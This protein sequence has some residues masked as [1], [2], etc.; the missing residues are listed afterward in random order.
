M[1]EVTFSLRMQVV[2]HHSPSRVVASSRLRARSRSFL[3][4]V[5]SHPPPR[6]FSAALRA[7]A[8]TLGEGRAGVARVGRRFFSPFLLCFSSALAR[9]RPHALATLRGGARVV[10]QC[11]AR[12]GDA[13]RAFFLTFFLP[14]L[15]PSLSKTAS[16][17]PCFCT[18][19][20]C[21]PRSLAR[22][23]SRRFF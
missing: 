6:T 5:H 23:R 21:A 1:G 2:R 15:L 8:P 18:G 9:P 3:F 16:S 22:P 11:G 12:C 17:C 13:Q 4:C 10:L 20:T 14:S 7:A 19:A